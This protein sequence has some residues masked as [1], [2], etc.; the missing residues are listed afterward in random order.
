[1]LGKGEVFLCLSCH[2]DTCGEWRSI[3]MHFKLCF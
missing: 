3:F 1:V 2:E